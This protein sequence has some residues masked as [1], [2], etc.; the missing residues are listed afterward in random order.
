[1][2]CDPLLNVV[3]LS[4][5]VLVIKLSGQAGALH[6]VQPKGGRRSGPL[7][8]IQASAQGPYEVTAAVSDIC[9]SQRRTET[10]KRRTETYKGP[11]P[12]AAGGLLACLSLHP[13]AL[14]TP[15]HAFVL[16]RRND[17]KS[18]GGFIQDTRGRGPNEKFTVERYHRNI[19]AIYQ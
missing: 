7:S 11:R 3:R 1:M 15:A 5:V 2:L 9:Q 13:I 4:Q 18:E 17:V 10:Y 19:T 8:L 6:T 16:R 12:F 14:R